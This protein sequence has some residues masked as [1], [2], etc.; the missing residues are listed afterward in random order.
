M[1]GYTGNNWS[2]RNSSKRFPEKFGSHT[3]KIINRFNTN[4]NCTWNATH[5]TEGTAVRSKKPK[6]W[7][8]PLEYRR[9]NACDKRQHIIVII[10]ATVA[11]LCL[12]YATVG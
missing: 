3:K 9:E 11:K 4:D 8:S 5:N 1:F 6:G 10:I 2:H 7:G 12:I